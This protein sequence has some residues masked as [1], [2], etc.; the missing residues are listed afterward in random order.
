MR[1]PTQYTDCIELYEGL[2]IS[3]VIIKRFNLGDLLRKISG[4]ISCIHLGITE[5]SDS[6]KNKHLENK[7]YILI[8]TVINEYQVLKLSLLHFRYVVC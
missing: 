8:D 6:C 2:F 3:L 4:K 1:N 7:S 5:V